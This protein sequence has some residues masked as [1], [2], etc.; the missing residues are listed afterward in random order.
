MIFRIE[1]RQHNAGNVTRQKE[2][3]IN[4]DFFETEIRSKLEPACN[5]VCTVTHSFLHTYSEHELILKIT[6][7]RFLF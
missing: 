1:E 6:A 7:A 4:V 3:S 5:D 2:R